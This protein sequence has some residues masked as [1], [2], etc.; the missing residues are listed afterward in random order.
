[1]VQKGTYVVP[2]IGAGEFVENA[3][4]SGRLT[5]LRAEKAL[6][7]AQGLRNSVRLAHRV[8][9]LIVLGTDAGVGEHG[10]NGHEFTLLVTWGGLTPMQAITAGASSGADLLGWGEKVGTPSPGK[11]AGVG[12][13]AGGPPPDIQ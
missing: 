2:T 1:M 10:A 9:V 6:A 12:A 13:G 7:A 5:G 8:G 4:K 11:W 3:A